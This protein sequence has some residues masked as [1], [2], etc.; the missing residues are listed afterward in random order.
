MYAPMAGCR[1]VYVIGKRHSIKIDSLICWFI[2]SSTHPFTE[3]LIH[4]FIDSQVHPCIDSLMQWL[5]ESPV[6]WAIDSRI[7]FI[8]S[9][10]HYST[11][12]LSHC[13]FIDSSPGYF[14]QSLIHWFMDSSI[15][16]WFLHWFIDS[17]VHWLIDSLSHCFVA[18]LI[19]G[20]IYSL[21]HWFIKSL[22]LWF[23]HSVVQ[24]L[25]HW[26]TSQ[27]QH[28]IASASQKLSYRPLIS[29]SNVLFSKLPPRRGPG[30]TWLC[31]LTVGH[32][33]VQ[34]KFFVRPKTIMGGVHFFLVPF[35]FFHSCLVGVM[36]RSVRL[37]TAAS[38]CSRLLASLP[39]SCTR[40]RMPLSSS[41]C[42]RL[43]VFQIFGCWLLF[44]Y[45]WAERHRPWYT[46][47]CGHDCFGFDRGVT[48][49]VWMIFLLGG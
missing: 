12:S 41:G 15:T 35:L 29:Y 30:T 44:W 42:R 34:G 22:A 38:R 23:I 48:Q 21:I 16:K 40:E 9:S 5:T 17:L 11:G 45:R 32:V 4:W 37:T 10:V 18:S 36:L 3:S 28:S 31:S 6:R 20:F 8:D 14:I 1:F 49:A 2:D 13:W 47:C 27:L 39:R 19:H 46:W 7:F 25:I 43:R 26:C 33:P 24:F